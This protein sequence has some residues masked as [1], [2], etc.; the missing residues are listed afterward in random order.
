MVLKRSSGRFHCSVHI[1]SVCGI[2]AGNFFLIR[3]VDCWQNLPSLAPHKLIID[4]EAKGLRISSEFSKREAGEFGRATHLRPFGA[5]N[6][7]DRGN[8]SLV[9]VGA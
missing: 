8:I 3:R 2:Y 6:S 7:L 5:V 1:R 4:E 9:N